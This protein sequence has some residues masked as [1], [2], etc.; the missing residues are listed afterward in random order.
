MPEQ[1]LT[2]NGILLQITEH[3]SA[4]YRWGN[5]T[6]L[7]Q[8]LCQ[9]NQE[10][11]D[12]MRQC[13]KTPGFLIPPREEPYVRQKVQTLLAMERQGEGGNMFLRDLLEDGFDRLFAAPHSG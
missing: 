4:G 9:E 10:F 2:L 6:P 11:K 1:M 7:L 5:L 13:I 8:V 12:D 3:L